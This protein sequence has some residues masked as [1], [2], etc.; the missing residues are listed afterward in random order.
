VLGSS[1]RH[2]HRAVL[3]LQRPNCLRI[4]QLNLF[5]LS[6]PATPLTSA[7]PPSPPQGAKALFE[8]A[9][10]VDPDHVPTLCCLGLMAQVPL[11]WRERRFNEEREKRAV[12]FRGRERRF[13]EEREKRSVPFRGR[14]R[15]GLMKREREALC[16]LGLMAQ[17]PLRWREK[18]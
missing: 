10:A 9:I 16:C 14:E 12:P 2:L 5:T 18:I 6:P 1:V 3:P 11:R 4:I 8:R 17:V 13:H 15:E 7:L